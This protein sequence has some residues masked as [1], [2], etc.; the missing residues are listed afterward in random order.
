MASPLK[1]QGS[2]QKAKIF[3]KHDYKL[4]TLSNVLSS[5]KHNVLEN[6]IISSALVEEMLLLSW[7]C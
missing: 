6:E 3:Y 5:L 2:V 7:S 1:T 4:W